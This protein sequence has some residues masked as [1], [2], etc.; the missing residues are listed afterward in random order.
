MP[1]VPPAPWVTRKDVLVGGSKPKILGNHF[2]EGDL[3]RPVTCLYEGHC[4][5]NN[6]EKSV[7]PKLRIIAEEF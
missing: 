1:W 6:V 5:L 7:V 4:K 2:G 3:L